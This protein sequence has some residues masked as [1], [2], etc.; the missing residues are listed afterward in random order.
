[1]TMTFAEANRIIERMA[2][3]LQ[4]GPH[5][6]RAEFAARNRHEKKLFYRICWGKCRR[7]IP[8][9]LIRAMERMVGTTTEAGERAKRKVIQSD[10]ISSTNQSRST[11]L[12]KLA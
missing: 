1:M 11:P 2:F 8:K 5:P 3:V 12:S 9:V 10:P 7:Y 6:D 4:N